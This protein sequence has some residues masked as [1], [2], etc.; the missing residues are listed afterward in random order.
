MGTGGV[1]VVCAAL[2]P[3]HPPRFLAL[4]L[5]R[6]VSCSA[7]IRHGPV[8]GRGARSGAHVRRVC[9][10]ARGGAEGVLCRGRGGRLWR[11]VVGPLRGL[12]A[13]QPGDDPGFSGQSEPYYHLAVR[14]SDPP[15]KRPPPNRDG[16]PGER[17]SRVD[18]D[19]ECKP[20][21]EDSLAYQSLKKLGKEDYCVATLRDFIVEEDSKLYHF[22]EVRPDYCGP[23]Y[24]PRFKNSSNSAPRDRL[25]RQAPGWPLNEA[26]CWFYNKEQR[27]RGGG[28]GT[29]LR[30]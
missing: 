15:Y 28:G 25:R 7:S 20:P 21:S 26:H 4:S 19:V 12:E 27:S 30:S 9:R 29:N 14:K 13:E 24:E 6:S 8:R 17:L 18:T 3:S 23:Q 16:E 1:V 22:A 2:S 5:R 10:R 11:P